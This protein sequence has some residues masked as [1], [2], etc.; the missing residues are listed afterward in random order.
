MTRLL[1]RS[2]VI[3]EIETSIFCFIGQTQ[4]LGVGD[5]DWSI[6]DKITSI[7]FPLSD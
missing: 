5:C 2:E 7:N 1:G 6:L 3:K 4:C